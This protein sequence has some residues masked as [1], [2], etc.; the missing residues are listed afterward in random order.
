MSFF[1]ILQ[2]AGISN[3]GAV[4]VPPNV[5]LTGTT[6]KLRE[7]RTF[8]SPLNVASIVV[9]DDGLGTNVLS[10]SGAD[11]ALFEINGTN[12]RLKSG[13]TLAYATNPVLSV[14]VNVKDVSSGG[15]SAL[16]ALSESYVND[17]NA[18][19]NYRND[20]APAEGTLT[21]YHG[22]VAEIVAYESF[23]GNTLQDAKFSSL[24]NTWCNANE[25]LTGKGG[26]ATQYDVHPVLCITAAK[27]TP[28]I[29][30]GLTETNRNKLTLMI[31]GAAVGAAWSGSASANAS[32]NLVGSENQP[33]NTPNWRTSIITTLWA[34]ATF[35]GGYGTPNFAGVLSFLQNFD[36]AAFHT[37][38]VNAGL[39]QLADTMKSRGGSTGF[40]GP[41]NATVEAALD[42]WQFIARTGPVHWDLD[43][44]GGILKA[45]L[46]FCFS[47]TI[48][49]GL[50]GGVGVTY[51]GEQRGIIMNG[52]GSL[53]NLGATGMLHQLNTTDGG[54]PN[55]TIV[56][57]SAMSYAIRTYFNAADI[58]LAC[59]LG[60]LVNPSTIPSVSALADRCE[61]GVRDF[62]YKNEQGYKSFAKG[63]DPNNGN[64]NENWTATSTL[65]VQHRVPTQLGVWRDI[66]DVWLRS[67]VTS[68][69]STTP[70]SIEVVPTVQYIGG[71]T[72]YSGGSVSFTG[73][74]TGD[75]LIAQ[76]F[77]GSDT[78]TITVPS[79]WTVI[80]TPT[81][82][83][84]IYSLQA[85]RW[86]TTDGAD[87][88]GTWTNATSVRYH[89]VRYANSTNPIAAYTNPVAQAS[90]TTITHPALTVGNA[91]NN[92]IL[93][94]STIR[95]STEGL[96]SGLRSDATNL[97]VRT[98]A[99]SSHSRYARATNYN[100]ATWASQNVATLTNANSGGSH[101]MVVEIRG[102][103]E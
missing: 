5:S 42:S 69:D 7:T 20:L 101:V 57:R 66:A 11:S 29:W 90:A 71:A 21:A 97:S 43:D 87:T 74:T 91:G 3:G 35:L 93:E 24:L 53:P 4:N 58:V 102:N 84:N 86:A 34:Y 12:L 17:A 37:L 62:E 67:T 63:G 6:T 94:A 103:N 22:L 16:P 95:Q 27:L 48:E 45:E 77:R 54:G 72:T 76:V 82:G 89:A 52:A 88:L 55:S 31:Q 36:K 38:C 47:N 9:T 15:S 70:L 85:Y 28:R 56:Q 79:G 59:V 30:S 73:Y 80:G 60:N 19:P 51:A 46:E 44:V 26:L 13:T 1:R 40:S 32:I 39:T 83:Q 96:A 75:L 100:V 2:R 65:A 98:A 33:K 81:A 49:A 92:I 8:A 50:N 25:D 23:R 78:T 14:N 64:N 68:Y 10:L 61:R 18:A 99:G 41:T